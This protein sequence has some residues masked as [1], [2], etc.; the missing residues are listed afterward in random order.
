MTQLHQLIQ[1]N[2]ATWQICQTPPGE[3]FI[4]VRTLEY[5]PRRSS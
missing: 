3:L 5:G 2:V 4:K 1:N